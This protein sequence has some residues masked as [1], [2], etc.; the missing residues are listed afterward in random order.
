MSTAT[1]PART[2][3][4]IKGGRYLFATQTPVFWAVV[5]TVGLSV[6]APTALRIYKEAL[7]VTGERFVTV[8]GVLRFYRSMLRSARTAAIVSLREVRDGTLTMD[9]A[10][11]RMADTFLRPLFNWKVREAFQE[12]EQESQITAIQNIVARAYAF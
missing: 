5:L 2:P 7:E 3:D 12:I 6:M 8:R 11:D 4:A 9:Q 1:A 10:Q